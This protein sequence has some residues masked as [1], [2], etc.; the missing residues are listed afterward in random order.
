MHPVEVHASKFGKFGKFGKQIQQ[1]LQEHN[2]DIEKVEVAISPGAA[3]KILEDEGYIEERNRYVLE[4]CKRNNLTLRDLFLC[5]STHYNL[6]GIDVDSVPL[7]Q[8][9]I[10][11]WKDF[12]DQ[13]KIQTIENSLKKGKSLES[14]LTDE[15]E[16]VREGAKLYL[17]HQCTLPLEE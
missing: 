9:A 13:Q 10:S 4:Y 15:C 14:M 5:R 2:F 1:T 12:S 17:E 3:I 11:M 6:N 8:A 7:Q 16:Q